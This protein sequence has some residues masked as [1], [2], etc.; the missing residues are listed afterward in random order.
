MSTNLFR[1]RLGHYPIGHLEEVDDELRA[2]TPPNCLLDVLDIHLTH[3]GPG[4]ARALM[5][6]REKHLNQAGA[7]QAGALIALA[8]A[9]AGWAAKTAVPDGQTFTTLELNANLVRPARRGELLE[10]VA[11]PVQVGRRVMVFQVDVRVH[12]QEGAEGKLAASFRCTE[13]VV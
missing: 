9:T 7:V 2:T 11:S 4:A 10:A 3:A 5:T 6:V 8:D 1:E 12:A 13:L